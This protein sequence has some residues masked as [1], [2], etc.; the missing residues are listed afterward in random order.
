MAYDGFF[1]TYK[2]DRETNERYDRIRSR[3]PNFRMVKI[4]LEDWSDPK[5]TR[6]V[7]ACAEGTNTKHFWV[8][9]PDCKVDDSFDFD[10]QTNEWDSNV[11][12]VWN[13]EERNVF[14]TVVGVKLFK[15][16][17]ISKQE[18][19]YISD[20]YFLTGEFKEHKTNQVEYKP[21]TETYDIFYW[22][23]EYGKNNLNK[24]RERFPELKT[25]TGNTHVEVHRKLREESRT[26]FYYLVLPNTD[27]FDTFNF[28]YSFAFGLDKENQKVVVWQ[29]QNP[30]TNLTREYHGVGL[31]PKDGPMFN[32]RQYQ[33]FNFRK[34]AVYEKDPISR[35]L[36]FPVIRTDNMHDLNHDVD[37]DM[38]W[39]V[40]NDVTEFDN[41]FY[42]FSYDREF[43]HNF[44]VLTSEGAEVRNG[45]RLV[46][47]ISDE[48]KQKDLD[49][50]IGKLK[51]VPIIE[52]ST[53]H[54]GLQKIKTYPSYIQDPAVIV[55]KGF[56]F[57][58][59]LYDMVSAHVL[60][61]GLVYVASE[62]DSFNIKNHELDVTNIPDYDVF[63]WDKG[64][65]KRNYKELKEKLP[66]LK[67]LK[68]TSVE[69]HEKAR[70]KSKYNYYYIVTPDT[71]VWDFN[72]DYEF[73]FSMTEESRQQ[74]VVWS[75]YDNKDAVREYYGVGLFRKDI[76]LFDDKQ[77][78]RFNFRRK[79]LYLDSDQLRDVQFDVVRTNDLHD[80]DN[81]IDTEMYW[82]IHD[83]VDTFDPS[84]YPP[85]YD[86]NIIHNFNVETKNGKVRN[87]IR[88]IPSFNADEE[89]QKDV[90]ITLGKLKE[91][92]KVEAR[93]LEEA[94]GI[95]KNN[96]FWMINPDLKAIGKTV[97]EFYPDL[98]ETGP[99]H[100]WKFKSRSG[101]DLG[102]GGIAFSNKD[103][104]A[105]N[106]ILHDDYAS[107][108]PDKHNI[109]KYYTRDPY[110]AFKQSKGK[111]F[112]WVV[113]T[114]VELREDFNFDYYPDIYSIENVF[115]FK[116]EEGGEAGV[117]L[118]HRPHLEK[119]NPSEEDFSFDRFKNIIRVDEVASRVVGHPAFYFDEGMYQTT[120]K[121]FHEHKNIDV[122]DASNG[123][124][125]AYQKAA[126]MTKTGYFWAVSNDCELKEDFNKTF[127]VDRHHKSHFHVWP[128]ENPY[129][130]Y[131]HQYGGLCLIPTAALKEL[132]PDDDKIRKMNFK[133]KKPVKSKTASSRDIPF[134]VVFLSYREKEAE[135]NY[136]KLLSRVPNAKRV[137][138]VKG[139]FNAHKRASEVAD[140]KM[141]YVL[142]ADAIL[143]DEFD[144]EY[145]PTVWDED[146]VHVW[147]SKN[148]INGLIYGF[149]GLKLFPTQL[150]RDA[151][152]W[153]I[154]FTTS[155]S[156]KFKPMPVVA[157]YTAFNTNPYDTWKSAFRECTKLSSGIIHNLKADEDKER[158]D[159]WCTVSDD[160]A[161]YGKYSIAGANAGRKFGSENADNPEKL[162]LINDY[163]WLTGQFRKEFDNE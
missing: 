60:S 160:N 59:D 53:L 69:V 155:I 156:D 25:V 79:A 149:G 104:H 151:K 97:D 65:G 138:G 54:G 87:G 41:D 98:Y 11:V 44:K 6:A 154:D 100:L 146:A 13:A 63:F 18:N 71:S 157:N 78:Q 57:Y 19:S 4:N 163:D 102:Y 81:K 74:I 110:K 93:T 118:V 12:H 120:A 31:F 95:A 136:A 90:D 99:T 94:V 103:Y 9:D 52:A 83:D 46:P 50:V 161:K 91:I 5:I 1:L 137:H 129:T 21:T 101:K 30:I 77:Y 39:L 49:T 17:D 108:I 141:F 107:R 27:I 32:E 55:D 75:R 109:K 67:K 84:Y 82:L 35:D 121:Y 43:I 66:R 64:F 128:K 105:D 2:N 38:Y 72:F 20:A 62:Y 92:E 14:R 73:E 142:D 51:K 123:L 76:D 114:A 70:K 23:R 68:G 96:T 48:E 106:I 162:G 42:P 15:T 147:K 127:Y 139:I 37:T 115:A 140:T 158:L 88:L 131:V 33:I 133:N 26:D 85:S 24:L 29:K 16:S 61:K 144:F 113:D 153:N 150:L 40:H 10:F 116:S 89:K 119:F 34:Q 86:R 152:D 135:E 8:I 126:K 125:D 134:D 3:Y 28:D 145:F 130:G 122:I 7:K 36:E 56:G 58:P 159:T 45:V 111:V 148:P 22:D 47:K 117:Y 124:S 132:K 143:L 112:Y 80:L